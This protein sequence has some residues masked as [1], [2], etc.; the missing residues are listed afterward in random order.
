MTK[1]EKDEFRELKFRV[2]KLEKIVK[3]LQGEHEDF[4]KQVESAFSECRWDVDYL[5]EQISA[6][7]DENQKEET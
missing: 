5:Q 6:L 4:Y 3:L 2:K 7:G 1:E